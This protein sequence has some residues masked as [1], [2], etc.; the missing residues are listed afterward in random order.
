MSIRIPY[1]IVGHEDEVRMTGE[2]VSYT[3]MYKMYVENRVKSDN[4]D[5]YEWS[6]NFFDMCEK[7]LNSKV[8]LKLMDDSSIRNMES[9]FSVFYLY[10]QINYLSSLIILI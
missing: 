2:D 3:K 8:H 9:D 10:R 5:D 6:C 1:I 7:T 4:R